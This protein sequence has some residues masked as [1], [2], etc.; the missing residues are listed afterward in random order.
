[1]SDAGQAQHGASNGDW[2]QP[3]T[4][5][6]GIGASAGGVNALSNFFEALPAEIGAAF[7]VIAHLDPESRSELTQILAAH[8]K[9]P[10]QQVTGTS[11][12]KP[13]C[14]YVIPPDRQ[15]RISE[16]EISAIPFE[17]PRGRRM[18]IDFFF[19]SLAEQHGDGF[20]VVLTGAGADGAVGVKAIKE[21]GGIILVQDPEQ[22]E[23][24]SMPRAAVATGAADVV[25]PIKEL[26]ERLAELARAKRQ[27]GGAIAIDGEDALRRIFAQLR[28]R[29]GHDFS[30]YK[31]STVLRR[32][33]RRMQVTR[34]D[35]F[36]E[37]FKYVRENAE[38]AQL[39]LTDLLISVT[40]FFRDSQA[41]ESLARNAIPHLFGNRDSSGPIRVWVA[42]CATGEEAYSIAMLLLE[43]AGR[44]DM[45]PEIQVFATDMDVRALAMA[46]EGRYP[47][48]IE[49]D[50]SEER[51]RR[52]F[53]SDGDEYQV[54]RELRDLVLFANHSVL[55]DPPFSRTDLI[56]CRNLLIYL[57]R[58]LQQQ[59]LMTLNY[60]LN[61]NGYLFL[62]SS[63]TAEHPDHLFRPIDREARLYQ[64]AGRADNPPLLPRLLGVRPSL[65][66]VGEAP[67]PRAVRVQH[68]EILETSAPPSILV[69]SSYRALHL[70]E[71]A[72]RYLLPPGGAFTPDVT[73]LVR[74]EIRFDLRS[75]L[76]RAFERNETTLSPLLMVKFNGAAHRLYFQ[77]KP[78]AA[79]SDASGAER[80]LIFFIE[81]EA[82][83]AALDASDDVRTA[84]GDAIQRLQQELEIS[85]GRLRNMGEES[86]AANEELRAANEELQSINEEYRSTA[87]E[88]ETSKE[89]LQSM[90]E[91]LQT[92]NSEL[93]LK[94]DS[95]SRANSDL[96]N[97]MSATDF[98]TLFLDPA[99]RIKLFTQPATEIFNV[100]Q[101]DIGRPLTDFT[102]QLIYE[103]LAADAR[104]VLKDLVP[105][106]SEVPSR[107][108]R[109][110]LARFRPYRTVEDKI[111]GVVATFV[112]ITQRKLWEARLRL[113]LGELT[114]RV[115]NILAVVQGMVHQAARVSSSK[116]DLVAGLDGRLAALAGSHRLLVDSDWSG[117]DL[118]KLIQ[119]EL[120]AYTFDPERLRISG[121]PA[122]LPADVATPFG[123]VLHELATNAIKY[124]ALSNEGGYVELSWSV[125]RADGHRQL[126]FHWREEDG[127]PVRT[128]SAQGFGSSLIQKGL[129]RATVKHE[130]FPEG[131]RCSIELPLAEGSSQ[132]S[133]GK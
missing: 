68:R 70:S 56:S 117:A 37:Y 63:E 45:R 26:A 34:K 124:G 3:R 42:G 13:D 73:E 105:A 61:R 27:T 113:L 21:R 104:K 33:A 54:K 22:A 58:D 109:W 24:S 25:L 7:V 115:K 39:L 12:L 133:A 55:K 50:V 69:D 111:D 35:N 31:R 77:V 80:A 15:L 125:E 36:D 128:P 95:V 16:D 100:T 23:Y 40:T 89:E 46:R 120:D 72:G 126:K 101:N 114:H 76:H 103:H 62:G 18:P 30:H 14:I 82:A 108:G 130:F 2:P 17:E 20:A 91:E 51:L 106:E 43:E 32:V 127:P 49:A 64:T 41:F 59:V 60:A 87:E 92:V 29:T 118:R 57:S 67:L 81:G 116:E 132:D 129:P 66:R 98:G 93:K 119:S 6:V 10:A 96:Q 28:V 78:I 86:E 84:A 19:R 8:S 107:D 85:H 122:M 44:Q 90:N 1:M 121:E 9:M 47:A 75:A 110:Y 123:L 74:D 4:T 97:L 71:N 52:F 11:E 38:E 99:L 112:E 83:P 102:H 48:A 65:G 5:V 79:A 131:V 94:L 88:L 53:Q